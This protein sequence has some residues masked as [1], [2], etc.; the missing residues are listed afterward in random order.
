MTSVSIIIPVYNG[1]K[2]IKA[3]IDSL[4]S[5]TLKDIEIIVVNDGSDDKTESILL[6]YG[7]RI[8]VISQR[9]KGQ[10]FARNAGIKAAAGEYI[11]FVDADDTVD[12]DMYELMYG[13][14]VEHGAQIVQCGIRDIKEDGSIADRAAFSENVTVT[15]RADYIFEYFYKLKHTNEVCNKLIQKRFLVENE[16][17]FDD[18]KLYFSEDFK[19][20]A[21]MLLR[22]EKISFLDRCMYNYYIKD[23]GHCRSDV[24][25]RITKILALFENVLENDMDSGTKK[26]LEC[27]AALTLLGYLREAM[28][29]SEAFA[30]KFLRDK[31]MKKYIRT[32]MLY[33]SSPKHF[34]LYFIINYFPMKI[35]LAVIDKFMNYQN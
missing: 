12:C 8:T 34:L 11:G 22:L 29:K 25:G 2:T 14:A 26:A 10:G 32:S 17:S 23:S 9:R 19:L 28:K 16:L 15:N 20:N 30:A 35:K 18:T 31:S 6:S 13:A 33:R 3:C 4:L 1:E 24:L 5:Q 7:K 21:E 27:V